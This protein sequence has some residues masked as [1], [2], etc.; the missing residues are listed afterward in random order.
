MWGWEA[1]LVAGVIRDQ[2]TFGQPHLIMGI[3]FDRPSHSPALRALEAM[4]H[5]MD[6]EE[7]PRGTVV[8]DRA[9]FGNAKPESFHIPLRKAGY[10]IVCDYK[11]NQLGRT[12]AYESMQLVEGT[13]YCPAMPQDLVDITTQFRQ[14]LIDEDTY[15]DKLGARHRF[16]MRRQGADDTGDTQAFMCPGRGKGKTVVCLLVQRREQDDARHRGLPT[17]PAPMIRPVQKSAVKGKCCTNK[18]S[19]VIPNDVGVRY[20]QTGPAYMSKDWQ[21]TYGTWRNVIETR[22]DYVKNNRGGA[23]IGDHTRRLVRGFAAAFFFTALG[24][25]AANVA[26]ISHFL[27]R[28]ER[29]ISLVPPPEDPPLSQRRVSDSVYPN[30]PPE[31]EAS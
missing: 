29:G 26:L 16:A 6:N 23:A 21:E 19:V 27:H 9:Y 14:G 30:A 8:G 20:R 25:V 28:V 13:W 15:R 12:N 10:T 4:R 22:N 24:V 7:S 3:A 1:T 18:A 31:R 17:I 11:I 5:L 2:G